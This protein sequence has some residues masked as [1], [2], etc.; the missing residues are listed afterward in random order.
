MKSTPNKPYNNAAKVLRKIRVKLAMS[1]PDL[2]K[3]IKASRQSIS[4]AER[5]LAYLAKPQL[6]VLV[7]LSPLAALYM[8]AYIVDKT[9]QARQRINKLRSK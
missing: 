2:G 8:D 3:I 7:K 9:E 6:K 4:N 1:Q 5:G